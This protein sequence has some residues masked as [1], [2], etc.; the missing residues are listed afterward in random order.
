MIL[1]FTGRGQRKAARRL[2]GVGVLTAIPAVASGLSDWTD[3]EGPAQRV[4]LVHASLN[5]TAVACYTVSWW[6][7]RRGGLAGQGWS[8]A[9]ATVATGAGWL[10]GHLAFSLG[11]GVDAGAFDQSQKHSRPEGPGPTEGVK[12]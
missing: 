3:T 5:A 6:A 1:D 10:G 4:G 7:R 2:V 9:G 11:V 8:L 12:P